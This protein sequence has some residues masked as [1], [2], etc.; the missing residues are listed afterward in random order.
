M[1]AR[2]RNY[3]V[4]LIGILLF[5]VMFLGCGGSGP[6]ETWPPSYGTAERVTHSSESAF[7]RSNWRDAVHFPAS[8]KPR[9]ISLGPIGE[10]RAVR[11][12]VLLAG[13]E[14]QGQGLTVSVGGEEVASSLM[15]R[16][17]L[18]SDL[19]LEFDP[20]RNYDPADECTVT[21]DVS[22]EYWVAPLELVNPEAVQPNVLVFLVDTLR[23]DH[24]SLYGYERQTTVH[25]DEFARTATVFDN[26]LSVSSWTRPAVGSLFTGTY[27]ST[28]GAQDYTDVMRNDVPRLAEVLKENGYRTYAY[29][30]NA[31]VHP[32]WGMGTEF[33][34]YGFYGIAQGDANV[35]RALYRVIPT[36]R[37]QK[38]FMYVHLL[39]PHGAYTPKTALFGKHKGKSRNEYRADI[40]A[41][42]AGPDEA[43]QRFASEGFGILE[44]GYQQAVDAI[45]WDT[46]TP[47]PLGDLIRESVDLYDSEIVDSD[48]YFNE[49]LEL[50]E[51]TGQLDNTIIVFLSDH[52]EEFYEHGNW[53][54]G[55]SLYEEG[56]RVPLVV[57]LPK[58]KQIGQRSDAMAQTVDVAPTILDLLDIAI[59][60]AMEG[61]SLK[62]IIDGEPMEERIGF[63]SLSH[64]SGK[65]TSLSSAVLGDHKV[66]VDH[67]SDTLEWYNLRLDPGEK[68]A[69]ADPPES[70]E[71]ILARIEEVRFR[72]RPG[73]HLIFTSPLRE[74]DKDIY[75]GTI[76]VTG[77]EEFELKYPASRYDLTRNGDTLTFRIEMSDED[78]VLDNHRATHAELYIAAEMSASVSVNVTL[79]GEPVSLVRVPTDDAPNDM[80]TTQ[81]GLTVES[82]LAPQ[83]KANAALVP[84][85]GRVHGWAI[86]SAD[87]VGVGEMDPDM[88]EALEGMGYL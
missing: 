48:E 46:Y 43:Y 62:P 67:F 7:Y 55:K 5:E 22:E 45:D 70:S 41:R 52:G 16:P 15:L 51:E 4:G 40:T 68:S 36:L 58:D 42:I 12:G 27:P 54:H 79:D 78:V 50:L 64:R 66:I 33:F 20:L 18:W 37:G 2:H 19:L 61:R 86:P 14:G 71:A 53:W 17:V 83:S 1:Y 63:S 13:T 8:S 24:C 39:D 10:A 80:D 34:N 81:G 29:A 23:T 75:E 21:F 6:V 49:V 77:M 30:R 3:L 28:H 85:D 65:P 59:P 72:S 82:F 31:N 57:R 25:L 88:R 32:Y 87:F 38:W 74:N 76:E 60:E 56:V 69:L 11:V 35:M 73:L 9:T 47:E 26:M 44:E 84:D